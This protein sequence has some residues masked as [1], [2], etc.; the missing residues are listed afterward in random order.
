MTSRT[1][2]I[3]SRMFEMASKTSDITDRTFGDI[4]VM[5]DD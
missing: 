4:Y 3:T 1:W 2:G 5:W